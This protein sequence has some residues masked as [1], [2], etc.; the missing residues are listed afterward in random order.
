MIGRV[1]IPLIGEHAHIDRA[2]RGVGAPGDVGCGNAVDLRLLQR[3]KLNLR[4]ATGQLLD[5]LSDIGLHVAVEAATGKLRLPARSLDGHRAGAVLHQI[6]GRHHELQAQVGMDEA[7]PLDHALRRIVVDHHPVELRQERVAIA[8]AAA[9]AAGL[10]CGLRRLRHAILAQRMR[11]CPFRG[12]AVG[13][14]LDARFQ[15]G[16][17]RQLG[18]HRRPG[19]GVIASL[20]H[21][22]DAEHIGLIFL[23]AAEAQR[24]QFRKLLCALR[25]QPAERVVPDD[26]AKHR[27]KHAEDRIILRRR[28]AR[29]RVVGGDVAGFVADDERQ[30]GLV[31]HDAHQL[32]GDVDVPA[33]DREGILDRRVQ[34]RE[35]IRLAG[36][37]G[38]RKRRHPAPDGFDIGRARSGLG[39]AKFGDHLRMLLDR[40]LDVALAE[41]ALLRHLRRCR[42]HD[43]GTGHQKCHFATHHALHNRSSI[44]ER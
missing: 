13:I 18:Q 28:F 11:T 19:V 3:S 43:Q 44:S 21:V 36:I 38:A 22:A 41:G 42:D 9:D 37:G 5:H 2:R 16:R 31:V 1:A 30:F 6:S 34:C 33:R 23:V 29:L 10:P 17:A 12:C 4:L 39:A 26:G 7:A 24:A 40:F 27:S 32:A 8:H 15:R 14:A 25:D 35:A 20:R